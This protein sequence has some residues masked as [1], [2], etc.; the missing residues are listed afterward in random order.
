MILYLWLEFFFLLPFLFFVISIFLL[1]ISPRYHSLRR[2]ASEWR[3][4]GSNNQTDAWLNNNP[5]NAWFSDWEPNNRETNTG[6][7]IQPWRMMP[8]STKKQKSIFAPYQKFVAN[9]FHLWR[10]KNQSLHPT[11][12]LWQIFFVCLI[13]L[14]AYW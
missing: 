3:D 1:L 4:R 8:S 6:L 12:N 2:K 13:G 7:R 9:N 10:S 11:R 5:T 14:W